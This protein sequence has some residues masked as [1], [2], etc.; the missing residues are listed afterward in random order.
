MIILLTVVL[1]IVGL[2]FL[3]IKGDIMVSVWL[4]SLYNDGIFSLE[5]RNLKMIKK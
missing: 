1:P 4:L 3:Q 2:L 5:L